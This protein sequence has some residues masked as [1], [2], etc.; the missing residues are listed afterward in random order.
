MMKIYALLVLVCATLMS[1][2]E[3]KEAPTFAE[4]GAP[5]PLASYLQDFY[6]DL[7]REITIDYNCTAS[8]LCTAAVLCSDN[9]YQSSAT[10]FNLRCTETCELVTVR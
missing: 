4:K 2:C 10:V 8:G 6:G 3:P 7:C 9:V 5:E 1:G